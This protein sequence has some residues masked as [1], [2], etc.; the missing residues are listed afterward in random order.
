MASELASEIRPFK[1]GGTPERNYKRLLS[2]LLLV[3]GEGGAGTGGYSRPP[4]E[5]DAGMDQT[6][7]L[8]WPGESDPEEPSDG[9][10]ESPKPVGRL[11]LLSSKYGP[12]KDFWIYPG[13]NV[14]G[15]LE[16]CPICLP[17]S[18][19]SKTH[20]IIEVPSP[21]GPHL[22]YDQESLNRTR[23]QRM[24][25]IPHVRYSLQDGDTLLFGDVGCQYFILDP[26]QDSESL[27]D[28]LEV[29][30]TQAITDANTLVIE[31]TPALRRKAGFR[32]LLVQDLDK[33]EEAVNGAGNMLRFSRDDGSDSSIKPGAQGHCSLASSVFSLSSPS[34]VPESDEENG[35]PSG[36][37]L[38][39]PS[40]RLR[41]ESNEAVTPSGVN[42]PVTP[43][44]P[45]TLP[46]QPGS[47]EAKVSPNSKGQLVAKDQDVSA[48]PS[49]TD[50]HLD[51]DTDVEDEDG[52][53]TT[54]ERTAVKDSLA[55]ELGSDTDV[56]E[57]PVEN[58]GVVSADIGQSAND[59]G[60]DTDI[61]EAEWNPSGLGFKAH[62]V[63]VDGDTD[64]EGAAGNGGV[65]S[66]ESRESILCCEDSGKGE[67]RAEGNPESN[68]PRE[69]ADSDTDADVV[70]Y[71][72]ANSKTQ[73][74][75]R[76]EE[77][78]RDVKEPSLGAEDQGGSKMTPP[79]GNEEDDTDVEEPSLGSEDQG[80][81]K[82]QPPTRNE[83][84][85]RDVEVPSLGAEDQ[86]GS[87]TQPPMG[88]EEGDTDV[89]VPSLGAEDQGGSKTQPPMGNEEDDT[90]VEEPSCGVED[91]GGSLKNHTASGDADI[92][93]KVADTEPERLD[94]A[95][96][97]SPQHMRN[98]GSDLDVGDLKGT[99]LQCDGE[100][101]EGA[102]EIKNADIELPKGYGD[103]GEQSTCLEGREPLA[104]TEIVQQ[105]TSMPQNQHLLAISLDSDTDMEEAAENP[106][107]SMWKSHEDT[108]PGPGGR[109]GGSC[110]GNP[111]VGPGEDKD[112]DTDVEVASPSPKALV[113]PHGDTDVEAEASSSPRRPLE[114]Q[115]TQL[116][117]LRPSM[118]G[119]ETAGSAAGSRVRHDPCEEDEDTDA[120]ANVFRDGDG[121][122]TDDEDSDLAVQ[123]TQCYLPTEA[124]S[125]KAE[126]ARDA[127]AAGSRC[128]LDEEATQA[129]VFR[130]PSSFQ[131][132]KTC[133]SPLKDDDADIYML[134]ATQPFC[135]GP[136]T[137]S[138]EPTQ[139]F[140]AEEEED[141]ELIAP[142][143]LQGKHL[144]EQ[145][146]Q[147][148]IP[149][150][151]IR[152]QQDSGLKGTTRLL[153][154]K[155][156]SGPGSRP[157]DG[158]T[159]EEPHKEEDIQMV[160]SGQA[161]HLSGSPPVAPLAS[162]KASGSEEQP[163]VAAPEVSVKPSQPQGAAGCVEGEPEESCSEL[164][165]EARGAEQLPQSATDE[166]SKPVALV[167]ERR[168]SLR[169]SAAASP[170]PAPTGRSSGRSGRVGPTA[171]GSSG[172]SAAAVPARR[173]GLRQL[174]NPVQY[175]EEPE[176][177]VEAPKTEEESPGKTPGKGEQ[178][179]Q[180]R[181]R[182]SQRISTSAT[183]PK[184]E[185][186]RAA[187][188]SPGAKQ[189]T[190]PRKRKAAAATTKPVEDE[191]PKHRSTRSRKRSGG[192]SVT[193]PSPK[194]SGKGSKVGK[195]SLL[196][197][198]SSGRRSR[199]QS[200]ESRPAQTTRKQSHSS[201]VSAAPP[202]KVL[203]TGVIDEEGERVITELG[204]S[205]AESVF[206]C[207]HLVTDRV[208]RTVKFLCALARGIPIVTL[209]WLEKS[210][211]NSFF[212]APNTFLVR[213]LEQEKNFQFS[214]A[215]S[216]K[217]AR[218]KGGLLQGY[219]L[220]V[221]PNV[222][223]EPEHMRDI[224][225][226][227]GG[228]FLP[229]MPRGYK[230][231]RVIISCPED[232]PRCK[233][234]HDAGVPIANSEFILTGILQQKVDLDAHRLD[235]VGPPSLPSPAT[236][237]RRASKRRAAA[238]T[239]PAP[240]STAKRRR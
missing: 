8:D 165:G 227:S 124:S 234:A 186:A 90:N 31:E 207:T 240:P 67:E 208:R 191:K 210:K 21:D 45:G 185:T 98:K 56:E 214:L 100:S 30:P 118:A 120:E 230:E 190:N 37:G 231:K 193:T 99:R 195:E 168:R 237:T 204:G 9:A 77:D 58:P 61:E 97:Q 87:K 102:R 178:V 15:R 140:I 187:S 2:R 14:I 142:Q 236:S 19:V 51:S 113:A 202:P 148:A 155:V 75:T 130:P 154:E 149:T 5:S 60:S 157:A 40:L 192:A 172:E 177:K 86:G 72:D 101:A 215:G 166:P 26:E 150:S 81:S 27:N 223:P 229:R 238:P 222:K 224:I 42:G 228:T 54:S 182:R 93:V 66:P 17:V 10:V 135:K 232:L 211:Q 25:L 91:Q 122:D 20:A 137:L 175:V 36:S 239:A 176:R 198:P 199:R 209:D 116:V 128:A 49:L 96:P 13:K 174:S 70:D 158:A 196:S 213:D 203:F 170:S 53:D 167:S 188:S 114:E 3:G 71:P 189:P 59:I 171:P 111:E 43:L 119:E 180:G 139:A 28:S 143:P 7:L 46:L 152:G 23:R 1:R 145:F 162:E 38:S 205:L 179:G 144:S 138:E 194:D 219:E 92:D 173:R 11:H 39:F 107:E 129:F 89:E 197:A 47:A 55:L 82:T 136:A 44:N 94:G 151:A 22:L 65:E 163:C 123:A 104:D 76:N 184:E 78:D 12:E 4:P 73:P 6:Q 74:P 33:E 41:Y 109:N 32:G 183:K 217:K 146:P 226:C 69:E 83:E 112:S 88:N 127:A 156:S 212:L 206:D 132:G 125:P 57:P 16:S 218:Q 169:A 84:D 35:E 108:S 95:H 164:S 63:T 134:E 52:V 80:G 161:P 147:P 126:K 131:P 133:S 62:Q 200:T 64:A 201:A 110:S 160:P 34:V 24:I 79:M 115:E 117:P 220:H 103:V 85:D 141:T 29:P 106:N 225:K 68:R 235:Q 50:F 48:D 153:S 121:A 159:A 221:T 233:L 216:L 181:L 18:S 105:M